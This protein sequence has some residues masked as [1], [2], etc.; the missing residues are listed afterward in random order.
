M[1]KF[2]IAVVAVVA[3]GGCI[4]LVANSGQDNNNTPGSDVASVTTVKASKP[5]ATSK[6]QAATSFNEGVYKVGSD[7]KPGLYKSTNGGYYARLKSED[8]SDI[9]TNDL[10][11]SG[12]MYCRVHA[13]DAYIDFSGGPWVRV[14]G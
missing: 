2:I 13:S 10:K 11:D 12:V 7:I 1:K 4:G 8:T 14:S 9:I 3:L 6:P 5:K